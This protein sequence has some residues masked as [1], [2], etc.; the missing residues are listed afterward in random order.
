MNKLL[1]GVIKYR[2][3]VKDDLVKQFKEIADNPKVKFMKIDFKI[4][5]NR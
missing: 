4:K 2:Q 1:R 5:E 3:T